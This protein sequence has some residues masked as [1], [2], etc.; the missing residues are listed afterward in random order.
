MPAEQSTLGAEIHIGSVTEQL[1]LN[2]MLPA[3]IVESCRRVLCR[4]RSNTS[5]RMKPGKCKTKTLA[6]QRNS[7]S[8]CSKWRT[9]GA[10]DAAS[11][12]TPATAACT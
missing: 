8:D 4:Q 11:E 2:E 6:L 10:F 12:Q 9:A 1:A 5:S 3:S 7:N